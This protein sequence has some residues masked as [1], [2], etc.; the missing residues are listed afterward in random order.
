MN[1]GIQMQNCE[2]GCQRSVAS[3]AGFSAI[4]GLMLFAIPMT[5][6][7]TEEPSYKVVQRLD[8]AEVRLY[9]GYTVAEVVVPGTSDEAGSRAFPILA[10]YIFGKNKGERKFAMTAPVTQS[11]EPVKLE[12]TAPVIQTAQTGGF[13]VQFVL[14]KGVTAATAP[15]PLD[16][17]I[18]LRDIAPSRVAVIRYSGFWSEANYK[19]HLASLQT[20]LRAADL[21]GVG[22]PLY[23]RYNAPFT[24]WF[25]RRNEIWLRLANPQ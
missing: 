25:L 1:A 3:F 23:S 8:G 14:P 5:I 2:E 22:E 11:A 21:V 7:A 6:H 24:P 13:R 4:F 10:G 16:S 15:E 19:Q 17:Q 12:M 18:M 20:A 9:D